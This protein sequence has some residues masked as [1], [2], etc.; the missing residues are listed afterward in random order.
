MTKATNLLF[1]RFENDNFS[2]RQSRGLTR[3]KFGQPYYYA[4]SSWNTDQQRE[5]HT[6]DK[7]K[8]PALLQRVHIYADRSTNR[9][10]ASFSQLEPCKPKFLG[11]NASKSAGLL[12]I[13]SLVTRKPA[14]FDKVCCFCT[15]SFHG[16]KSSSAFMQKF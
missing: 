13:I 14:L 10:L 3:E 4:Y 8:K 16:V 5:E 1:I 11:D 6:W 9:G 2:L 15:G 12:R 7:K